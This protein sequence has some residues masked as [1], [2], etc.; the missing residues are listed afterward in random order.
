MQSLEPGLAQAQVLDEGHLD[1]AVGVVVIVARGLTIIF[2]ICDDPAASLSWRVS[3]PH[4]CGI[5]L[6]MLA[7]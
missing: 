1:H 5:C 3:H 7:S 2:G 4:T 6:E